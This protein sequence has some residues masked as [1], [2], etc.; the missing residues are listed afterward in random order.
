MKDYAPAGSGEN[1]VAVVFDKDS[2]VQQNLGYG[3]EVF[4]ARGSCITLEVADI[5]LNR[6]GIVHGGILSLLLDVAM[7]YACSGKFSD[8]AQTPAITLSMSTSYLASVGSGKV[9]ATGR[10]TGGGYKILFAEAV[11]T[12]ESGVVIATSS[13]TMKRG[14]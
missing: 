6:Q 4:G 14:G 2:G 9:I 10:V 8:D 12:A 5:H 11:L 1:A 3:I 7:G 13:G